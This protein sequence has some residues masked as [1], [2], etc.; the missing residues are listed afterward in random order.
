[1]AV[2][3]RDIE[4]KCFRLV[5]RARVEN[6]P[7][8]RDFRPNYARIIPRE[9]PRPMGRDGGGNTGTRP[10]SKPQQSKVTCYLCGGPHYKNECPQN[11]NRAPIMYAGREIVQE[12][13]EIGPAENAGPPPQPVPPAPPTEHLKHM[14]EEYDAEDAVEEDEQYDSEYTLEECTE[15]SFYEDDERCF[16]MGA[17]EEDYEGL[18]CLQ[19]VEN[20]D[21]ESESEF[22]FDEADDELSPSKMVGDSSESNSESGYDLDLFDADSCFEDDELDKNPDSSGYQRLRKWGSL[23]FVMTTRMGI[24]HRKRY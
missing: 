15:Y 23:G 3:Q 5:K 4:N 8:K 7:R 24:Y 9:T 11:K 13:E 20:S 2:G 14:A 18:P 12:Q 17:E 21:S 1:M 6:E 22:C 10:Y 19:E 16:H